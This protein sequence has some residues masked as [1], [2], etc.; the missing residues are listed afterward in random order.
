MYD[1]TKMCYLICDLKNDKE[2]KHTTNWFMIP[3][4]GTI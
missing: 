2:T 3:F 4:M 1:D